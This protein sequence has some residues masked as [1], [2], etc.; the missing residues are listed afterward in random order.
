MYTCHSPIYNYIIVIVV[1][2][3]YCI[4]PVCRGYVMGVLEIEEYLFE[5]LFEERFD[6]K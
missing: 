2:L 3:V 6:T 5:D 1:Y 4:I